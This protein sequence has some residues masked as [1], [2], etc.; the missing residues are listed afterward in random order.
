M[1]PT[2]F[3]ENRVSAKTPNAIWFKRLMYTEVIVL[4]IVNLIFLWFALDKISQAHILTYTVYAFIFSI[5]LV[6]LTRDAL[7]V[8]YFILAAFVM[9]WTECLIYPYLLFPHF[10]PKIF[11]QYWLVFS[12]GFFAILLR[13]F[14]LPILKYS[15]L[16]K[17]VLNRQCYLNEG[18]IY[19]GWGNKANKKLIKLKY[20]YGTR[21]QKNLQIMFDLIAAS[22]LIFVM[23]KGGI[24]AFKTMPL[25]MFKGYTM[26][27]A[28]T[29]I[30]ILFAPC[31]KFMICTVWILLRAKKARKIRFVFASDDT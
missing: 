9:I 22:L 4:P 14:F 23:Y 7:I 16:K 3:N 21:S 30:A 24:F 5:C 1:L 17:L 2:K 19:M 26:V 18:I 29:L 8:L 11:N 31:A 6:C 10:I 28:A 12:I 25:M 20:Y 15:T 27:C 13:H